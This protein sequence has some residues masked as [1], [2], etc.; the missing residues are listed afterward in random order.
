MTKNNSW[1]KRSNVV[2]STNPD[3]EYET[4][5]T[6]ENIGTLTPAQQNLRI[7][8]D[9]RN[10]KGKAVTLVSGFI[11]NNDDLTELGKILK[12]KCGVGGSVKNGEL[13][14]QG[15]FRD[16]ILELLTKQGYHCKISGK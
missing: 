15:D 8:L 13:L 1:K 16:K 7:M 5:N 10:R 3:F 2:F 14:I 9:K 12:S 11:G 4:E 6:N